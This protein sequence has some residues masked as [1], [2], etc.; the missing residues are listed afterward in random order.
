MAVIGNL[1]T[2]AS[3]C[4]HCT[5]HILRVFNGSIKEAV[6][7]LPNKCFFGTAC[8]ITI[9]QWMMPPDS[10]CLKGLND[11]ETARAKC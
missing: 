11:T 8:A 7:C 1:N 3:S 9:A 2:K 4:C 5:L 6:Q 10:K